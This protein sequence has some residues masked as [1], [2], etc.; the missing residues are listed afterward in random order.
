MKRLTLIPKNDTITICLPPDWVGKVINC[1]LQNT[2]EK[3]EVA[4]PLAAEKN[5]PYHVKRKRR[6]K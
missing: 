1:T 3:A 2:A 6:M 4:Y 5:A